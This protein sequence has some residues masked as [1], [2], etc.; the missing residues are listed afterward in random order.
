MPPDLV[1]P[2]PEETGVLGP[3]V[4]VIGTA[5]A[6]MAVHILT[7][8]YENYINNIYNFDATTLQMNTYSFIKEQCCPRCKI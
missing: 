1:L 6:N 2:T 7:G 4:G 5:A 3:V 8:N